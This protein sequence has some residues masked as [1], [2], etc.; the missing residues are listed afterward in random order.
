MRSYYYLTSGVAVIDMKDGNFLFKSDTLAVKLGGASTVFLV[1][2]ILP[3]LNGNN[4]LNDVCALVEKIARDDLK[5]NLDKLVKAGVLRCSENSISNSNKGEK[6]APFFNNFLDTIGY[7]RQETL[8][9]LSKAKIAVLGLEA[10]GT[11]TVLALLQSGITNL[12]LVDPFLCDD[13]YHQTFPFIDNVDGSRQEVLKRYLEQKYPA[14]SVEVF[15]HENLTK[16]TLTTFVQD[17]SLLICCF[18]SGFASAFYWTNQ[19]SVNNKIPALYAS[20]KGHI[21]F[22]GP[23]VIPEKTACYMC[24]MM[25]LVAAQEDFEE[26]MLYEEYLNDKK[27]PSFNIRSV[28]PGALNYTAATLSSEVL[29]FLFA[30]GPLSLPDKVLEYNTITFESKTHNLIVKPD[31]PVCQKKNDSRIHYSI[32]ELI[33]AHDPSNLGNLL[34]DLTSER[35]GIIKQLET[36][37]KDISEP[38]LPFVYMAA[39]ANHTFLPKDQHQ[40]LNCSGKGMDRLSAQISAG[41]EAVERYSGTVYAFNEVIYRSYD[42]LSD[43]ALNP[44]QLVLYAPEQYKNSAFSPFDPKAEIGWVNAFSLINNESIYIPAQSTILNYKVQK[45]EEYLCQATSNGLA[46]GSSMLNAILSAAGEV[47]ERD[48]FMIAWHN[49]LPCKRVNPLTHPSNEVSELY[50][51]YQ[52]RGVE[53]QLYKIPTDT[54]LHVFMGIGVQMKGDGPAAVVGLGADFSAIKAAKGAL[55]E[56]GQVRPAFKQRLRLPQTQDRLKQLL[57]DPKN[58]EELEDH[59]L[60]YGVP[61]KMAAFDFLFNQHEVDFDWESEEEKSPQEQLELLTDFFMQQNSDFIYFNL[62]PPDMRQFGLFTARVIL[63]DFQPIHFGYNNIRLGG[64][65]LFEL[66]KKLGFR[67][68]RTPISELN[69]NPHP[70]A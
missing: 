46:A 52:R 39:L 29:K 66:P 64:N 50:L 8:D 10:H 58:V 22:I 13:G 61:D 49:Q 15:N 21:C 68:T 70:L 65:R 28:L 17:C 11:Q 6:S 48:A 1:Q 69:M 63:P 43:R 62:T 5:Q 20:I 47:I 12:K 36:V 37:P 9:I 4:E 57:D 24:Y 26:A 30:F 16:E 32:P 41:G 35:I 3:L 42:S 19:I 7:T 60:L 27:S 54:P 51:A 31:C 14:A 33:K 56:V 18:D 67:V 53:L 44:Q 55:L 23:F 45:K 59:D 34:K 2:H 40:K 38:P 25:R